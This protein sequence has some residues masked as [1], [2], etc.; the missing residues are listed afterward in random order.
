MNDLEKLKY[1]TLL[2]RKSNKKS[3]PKGIAS[4]CI[5]KYK[6][7]DFFLTVQ[8][9]YSNANKGKDEDWGILC[10]ANLKNG[11][12]MY[13][14][15]AMGFGIKIPN[16]PQ[17][18][19]KLSEAL[20]SEKC[21]NILKSQGATDVDFAYAK[22]DFP[23]VQ[24]IQASPS[25]I[26]T[27]DEPFQIIEDDL[28]TLPS[29]LETYKFW[30]NI[31]PG[32]KVDTLIQVEGSQFPCHITEIVCYDNLKYT[33]QKGDRFL[34]EISMNIDPDFVRGCSGAPIFDSKGNLVALLTECY[35]IKKK[36]MNNGRYVRSITVTQI[37]GINLQ[38][39]KTFLD[40]NIS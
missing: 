6:G 2:L 17:N 25:L 36:L 4:G 27:Y 10:G 3:P 28:N 12:A 16:N 23:Q 7:T 26:L 15:G 1:S 32:E 37:E 22:I 34:F 18:I 38:L 13:F 11:A 40:V 21:V 5:L 29:E 19:E 35:P 24:S 30:G 31:K 33:G 9:I 39:C 20:A 8:H 14:P